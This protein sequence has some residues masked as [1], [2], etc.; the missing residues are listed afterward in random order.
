MT[1]LYICHRA[2][3]KNEIPEEVAT[4]ISPRLNPLNKRRFM[5]NFW[6]PPVTEMMRRGSGILQQSLISFHRFARSSS[7]SFSL[8]NPL[9][10]TYYSANSDDL[11]FIWVEIMCKY[12]LQQFLVRIS[13]FL[14]P[15]QKSDIAS[16]SCRS[17]RDLTRVF[18]I[19]RHDGLQIHFIEFL[20]R[21]PLKA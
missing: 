12:I 1:L 17:V 8:L 4:F 3:H 15:N 2:K 18:T 6:A 13:Y 5:K 14:P 11:V 20:W 10:H 19:H 16:Q 7:S 21:T 9:T